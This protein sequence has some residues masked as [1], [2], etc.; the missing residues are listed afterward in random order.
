MGGWISLVSWREVVG[1]AGCAGYCSL[2]NSALKGAHGR[3][4]AIPYVVACHKL[5]WPRDNFFFLRTFL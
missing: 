5:T 1:A 4:E 2:M 3:R